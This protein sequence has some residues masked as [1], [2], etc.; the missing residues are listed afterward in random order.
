[1]FSL[2]RTLSLRYLQQRRARAL[3]VVAS[4]AL[5]VA[6]LVAT[7]ALNGAIARAGSNAVNPMAATSDLQVSNDEAGV[8]RELLEKLRLVKV[9]GLRLIVPLVLG[10][11][12]LPELG[13]RV[14]TVFGVEQDV[15]KTGD[16][17]WQVEIKTEIGVQ[18]T[19]TLFQFR[20][21]AFVGKKLADDLS[22]GVVKLKVRA[23]GQEHT[24]L[25]VGRVEAHGQASMLSGDVLFL[26]LHD[27]ARLLGRP[28]YVS[29]IDLY[30]KPDADREAVRARVEQVLDGMAKVQDPDANDKAYRDVLAGLE[31]GFK[32]GG[33]IA[34]VVGL[35]LVYIVMEVT[36]AERRRDIGTMRALG[37]TRRQIRRLFVTEATLLGLAGSALGVPLGWGLALFAMGPV[38]RAISDVFL[39][40]HVQAVEVGWPLVLAAVAAGV[41]TARAAALVPAM[42][43]S[44]EEP[45]DA[46]RRA[47]RRFHSLWFVLQVA[48][49]A[50]LLATGLTLMACREQLPQRVGTYG[51][52]LLVLVGTLVSAPLISVFA[53]RLL[54]PVFRRLLGLEGRM[55][56]D[57][58]ARS[59]RRTGVVI[60]VVAAVV[61][62]VLQTAGLILS[63]EKAILQWV[64]DSFAADI[65]VTANSPVTASGQG[66]PMEEAFG[67]QLAA[68]P[69][70]EAV[71]PVRFQKC[72][73]RD[74]IVYLTAFDALASHGMDRHRA[75]VP[76]LEKLPELKTL[77]NV[78]VSENFAALH[79]VHEGDAFTL[80]GPRGPVAL[81]VIGKLVDYSWNRGT[82]FMDRERYIELFDDPLVDLF[83][84][85]L[86]QGATPAEVR[87]TQETIQKRWWAEMGLVAITRAQLREDIRALILRLYS[88]AYAQEFIIGLVAAL[89]LVTVL[90]ISVLQRTRDLGLL[91]AVGATQ[92][93]LMRSVLAE[94][95]L[96]GVI[97]CLIGLALGLPLEWFVVRV[98][99]LEDAGFSFPVQIPWL[100]TA[101]VLGLGLA[102]AVLA[103][104]GPAVHAMRLRIAEAIA[105]E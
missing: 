44:S 29:R 49:S 14:A 32:L 65:L 16:S 86:R 42:E 90:V 99:L 19:L 2:Y 94:A 41:L 33:V 31:V 54:K 36:V 89:G 100:A 50:G 48:A 62:L 76:G 55:A 59:P 83:D 81:R 66:L 104:L 47:P 35:F 69:G 58:L 93:Q 75:P 9:P 28:D 74:K 12:A 45:A 37:A 10:R 84:V 23:A 80:Q 7:Q 63:S 105:Y 85:Y 15:V 79:G 40:V 91:R 34:L 24:V 43:A 22:G 95:V 17:P 25:K 57:N 1:M 38:Q 102:I 13:N 97:G 18:D 3:L 77:G 46:V 92:A 4:I 26:D 101:V 30:L 87:A 68:L 52:V 61:A 88:V 39:P 70:V 20:T 72:H 5:G 60:A 53:S 8:R 82:I 6:M 78:I 103:G 67:R 51:G 11:A 27:A 21:Q 73:F 96:M 64:D 98:V 71:L 56:A